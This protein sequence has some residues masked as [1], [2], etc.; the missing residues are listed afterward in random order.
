MADAHTAEVGMIHA[1]FYVGFEVL[2]GDRILKLHI[3]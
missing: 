1:P 2:C 3:V